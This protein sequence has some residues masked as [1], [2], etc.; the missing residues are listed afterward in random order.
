MSPEALRRAIDQ[1]PV[2]P[3]ALIV[4]HQNCAVADIDVLVDLARS[5]SVP[6]VEDCSQAH[7]ASIC[8]QPVGTFGDVGVFSFQQNKMMT[9]GEG[10]AAITSD[11]ELYRRMQQFRAV[12]RQY[13]L[14]EASGAVE[15]SEIGDVIGD[16]MVLSEF[17]AAILL[18]QLARFP[19]QH[20]RR[21][22]NVA[23]LESLLD[24]WTWLTPLTASPR[25]TDR[26]YHKYVWRL[27]RSQVSGIS[28]SLFARA[29][30][31]E[32]VREVGVVDS[33]FDENPLLRQ[34]GLTAR[35]PRG[36]DE[37]GAAG[38]ATSQLAQCETLVEARRARQ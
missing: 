8:R 28:A 22:E 36:G 20:L 15:L 34:A 5:H 17:H 9:C 30:S 38:I 19:R 1:V 2:R 10:G 25:G 21:R 7:G 16:S 13:R 11:D 26:A 29:L 18:D 4:V 32:L 6:V 23:Y 27:D 12:G 24:G 31:A 37:S 14:D 3:T 33:S 35:L